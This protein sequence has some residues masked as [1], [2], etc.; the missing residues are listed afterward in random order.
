MCIN[1]LTNPEA[2]ITSRPPHQFHTKRLFLFITRYILAL[3]SVHCIFHTPSETMTA[4]P[5]PACHRG[6]VCN[7]GDEMNRICM[8]NQLC[9]K[10]KQHW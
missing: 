2:E 3:I 7:D 4:F 10:F 8:H 1:T 5:T 6:E 9:I